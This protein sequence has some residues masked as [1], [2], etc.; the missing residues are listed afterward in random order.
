VKPTL[1]LV[2]PPASLADLDLDDDDFDLDDLDLSALARIGLN[3]E[4]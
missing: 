1:R 4:N 2:E 3:L